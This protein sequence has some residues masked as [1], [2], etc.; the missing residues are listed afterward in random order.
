MDRASVVKVIV[1]LGFVV[2]VLGCCGGSQIG[3]LDFRSG[4]GSGEL[5][6]FQLLNNSHIIYSDVNLTKNGE[7]WV[8]VVSDYPI[9]ILVMDRGNFTSYYATEQGNWTG[10]SAYATKVNVTNG[11]LNYTAPAD[12]DLPAR[13]R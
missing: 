10:W 13:H 5:R 11:R 8:N 3:Y 7:V 12:E 6:S 9:D 1:I 2:L 4:S